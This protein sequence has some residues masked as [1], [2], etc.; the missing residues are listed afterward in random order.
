[1]LPCVLAML[2]WKRFLFLSQ[3]SSPFYAAFLNF[4]LVAFCAVAV[5][6]VVMVLARDVLELAAALVWK[7]VLRVEKMF[8][9][10][11]GIGVYPHYK[12]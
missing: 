1:M 6:S 2:C 5:V 10:N 3:E 4:H 11:L 9:N 12:N 7:L 8:H